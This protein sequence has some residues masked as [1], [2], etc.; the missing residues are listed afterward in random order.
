MKTFGID[1][2]VWQGDIDLL[3][4]KNVDGVKFVII[5][6]GGADDGLYKDSK[7]ERNYTEAKKL[8]LPVGAY[9]FGRA[10]T[11]QGAREEANYCSKLLAGKKFEL[12]VYYDVENVHQLAVGRKN[13]SD[14]ILAFIKRMTDNGYFTG[15]YTSG[16]TFNG[17]ID[18]SML[19]GIPHW[20]AHYARHYGFP[21][22]NDMGM[23]Q[24][25]GEENYI[26]SN[27]IAGVTCDQDY[28]YVDYTPAIK[29]AGLNGWSD[30]KPITELV[31][32]LMDEMKRRLEDEGYDWNIAREEIIKYLTEEDYPL[33]TFVVDVQ[34]A[35]GA[36]VDG[37]AGQETLN[38]TPTISAYVND[39]HPVIKPVQRRL[40]ALGYNAGTVDGVAGTLFTSS[41]KAFQRDHGCV[42]DG[43][44]TAQCKTWYELLHAVGGA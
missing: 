4:A 1:I 40:N 8:A 25:G 38:K 27:K 19:A 30:K 43:V 21:A 11:E 6:C 24:Y 31:P 2:S 26:R 13:L 37:I 42:V 33:H 10:E 7:F 39:T 5:K 22:I 44:A 17:F 29:E 28:L 35:I 16:C 15:I 23:W 34:R 3:T 14:I 20:V 18:D 36:V 9:F 12:P 32:E 41:I